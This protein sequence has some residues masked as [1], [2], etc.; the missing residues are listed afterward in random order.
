MT[1]K[2]AESSAIFSQKNTE[3]EQMLDKRV[4]EIVLHRH[5]AI[6]QYISI[7]TNIFTYCIYECATNLYHEFILPQD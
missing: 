2:K 4:L 5:H 6:F 1:V 7:C 3:F